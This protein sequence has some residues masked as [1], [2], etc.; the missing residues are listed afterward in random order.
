MKEVVSIIE[1]DQAISS[2][3]M[4]AANSPAYAGRFRIEKLRD[5]IVHLGIST[6]LD[7]ALGNYLRS[8]K[9]SAPLYDLSENDLWMHA[10][11]SSLAVKAIMQESHNTQIPPIAT[12]AALVHDIGKLVMV[13]YMDGKVQD[14]LDL[15]EKEHLSFVEAERKQFGCDHA[16]VG[17]VMAK[18]WGFP[19]AIQQA[20]E[21]HHSAPLLDPP[22]TV[23]VVI[24]ANL[25]AKSIGIGLGAEGMNLRTDSTKSRERV[26]MSLEGFER[27]CAQTAIWLTGLKKSYGLN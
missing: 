14:I 3:V 17:K 22:L 15:A 8:L 25:V 11:A 24:L 16:E 9:V 10:A 13:R 6:L 20:I 23:D 12:V 1:F 5:A 18:K 7:I 4:R 2:N 21:L 27:T 19:E 26:G